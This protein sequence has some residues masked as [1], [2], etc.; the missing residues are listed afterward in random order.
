[1]L[2][3]LP[4]SV[5][6]LTYNEGRNIQDCLRSVVG[7]AS[8]IIVV[9]SGSTDATRD[10]A[11]RYTDHLIEHPFENYSRQRNWA[12]NN[13]PLQ[14]EWVF[15]IDAD[16]RVSPELADSLLAFF[17][18]GQADRVN[19]AMFSR[20]TV[21]MGRWIRHGGHYPV[22]HTRLYRRDQGRCEDR[23][24]DQHFIVTPPVAKL[25][26]DLI[27]VLTSELDVWSARHIR[28]A[29]AEADEMQRAAEDRPGQI[30]PALTNGPVARR[31]WLRTRVFGRSPLFMR[32]FLYFFYRYVVRRGFLDG[33]EGLIFH[34][35]H[36]CWYRFYIDAKIWEHTR[37]GGIPAQDHE[38][39]R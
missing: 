34:F 6:V 27:D 25:T 29:A 22:F 35:L 12:Q 7:W 24:Y 33:A 17:R 26:G 39:R 9:D 37:N 23:L 20:R 38:Q 10:L 30:V 18:S 21:F 28:W 3:R 5:I 2:E 8:E 13:L 16:E 14:Y 11:S 15:H 1:M 4:V 31:R 19:G 36:G 32:A